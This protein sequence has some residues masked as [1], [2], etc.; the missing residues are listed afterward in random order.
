MKMGLELHLSFTHQCCTK[1][2]E[3]EKNIQKDSMIQIYTATASHSNLLLGEI[4]RIVGLATSIARYMFL[5][6]KL[7]DNELLL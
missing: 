7:V 6:K 2:K 3:E 4:A 1:V 5:V